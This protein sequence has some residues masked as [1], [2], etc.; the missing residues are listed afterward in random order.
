MYD[1]ILLIL[2]ITFC[3]HLAITFFSVSLSFMNILLLMLFDC[4]S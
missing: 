2:L 1:I 3:S 4:Y